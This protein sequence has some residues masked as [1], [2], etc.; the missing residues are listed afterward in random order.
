MVKENAKVIS[1]LEKLREKKNMSMS[2]PSYLL[3]RASRDWMKEKP[4]I[5]P[6]KSESNCWLKKWS[7][8]KPSCLL[9]YYRVRFFML[10]A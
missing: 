7:E 5:M 9:R 1:E 3:T 6:K 4:S 10:K 8:K 2:N